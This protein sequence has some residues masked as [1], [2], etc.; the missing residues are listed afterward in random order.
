M[1]KDNM[2][3]I[4][5]LLIITIIVSLLT[6][7]STLSRDLVDFCDTNPHSRLCEDR[8]DLRDELDSVGTENIQDYIDFGEI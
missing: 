3:R 1:Y 2:M 5:V 7:S 6:A 4:K 8:E